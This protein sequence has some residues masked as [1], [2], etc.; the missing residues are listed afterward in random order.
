M[1]G[2]IYHN[3]AYLCVCSSSLTRLRRECVP[4]YWSL[5]MCVYACRY[6]E[7]CHAQEQICVSQSLWHWI[8]ISK[9]KALQIIFGRI[10]F[11]IVAF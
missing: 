7:V 4:V 3:H 1:H 5:L 9:K 2:G 11:G 8:W 10:R 6:A